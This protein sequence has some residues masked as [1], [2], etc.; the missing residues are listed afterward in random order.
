MGHYDRKP[1]GR[2]PE[3]S[4]WVSHNRGRLP[5][6]A[7]A[8]A[9][10]DDRS[11]WKLPH[12]WID[13]L[14]TLWAHRGGVNAAYR[15]VG[16][17]DIPE[18]GKVRARSHLGRHRGHFSGG[19]VMLEKAVIDGALS[20]LKDGEATLEV[21]KVVSVIDGLVG[22]REELEAALSEKSE[23]VEEFRALQKTNVSEIDR[24]TA[25]VGEKDSV[26]AE[27]DAEI[28]R[29]GAEASTFGD[30]IKE[31]EA[32]V[33][34]TQEVA[35]GVSAQLEQVKADRVEVILGKM[36]LCGSEAVD[37]AAA[38]G[39]LSALDLDSLGS[40]LATVDQEYRRKFLISP[41]GDEE[42]SGGVLS[43]LSVVRV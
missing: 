34:A 20:M 27:R 7:F 35:D 28:V 16:R 8:Y 17:A 37:L 43:G 30:R 11:K 12:H 42:P 6:D 1:N 29:L 36:E 40:E 33:V 21:D 2:E 23:D 41:V 10:G 15:M 3:W 26:V 9:V 14:G 32:D 25:E 31:L 5:R 13:G 22:D 4:T 19:L 38:K 18:A 24:L 39:R